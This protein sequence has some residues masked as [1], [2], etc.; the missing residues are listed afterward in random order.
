MSCFCYL[1]C[2]KCRRIN[3]TVIAVWKEPYN[4][5][6][7]AAHD[8]YL[9]YLGEDKA[10]SLPSSGMVTPVSSDYLPTAIQS[11]ED[12]LYQY[13]LPADHSEPITDVVVSSLDSVPKGFTVVSLGEF[14]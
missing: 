8:E 9:K 1:L 13:M 12:L 3:D 5:S 10:P 14:Y 6:S 2:V 11:T 4:I 7:L